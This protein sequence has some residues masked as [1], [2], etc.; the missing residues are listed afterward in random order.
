MSFT[1]S[2]D[3]TAPVDYVRFHTGQTVEGESFISDEEIQSLLE[4]EGSAQAAVIA[5]LGY[6]VSRLSQPDFR[7]DW[8]QIDHAEARQ[9]YEGLLARK[10]AELGQGGLTAK[11]IT[12]YRRDGR[13]GRYRDS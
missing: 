10:R 8:L 5:A 9:G 4:T 12:T 1:Y 11:A 7:A 3:L 6:I 13:E 2:G